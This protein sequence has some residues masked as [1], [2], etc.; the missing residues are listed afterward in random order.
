[1]Q[2]KDIPHRTRLRELL[3]HRYKAEMEKLRSDLQVCHS[4]SLQ[5][6]AL[7]LHAIAI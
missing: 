2:D 5:V 6:R 3:I 7:T 4:S 1:M